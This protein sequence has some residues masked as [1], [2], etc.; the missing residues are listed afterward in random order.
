[1][2]TAVKE[3]RDRSDVAKALGVIFGIPVI[4]GLMLFCVPRAHIRVRSR[5]CTGG[6]ECAGADGA[7]ADAGNLTKGRG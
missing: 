6:G 1:M 5:R 7:A 4:I 2:T 3:E